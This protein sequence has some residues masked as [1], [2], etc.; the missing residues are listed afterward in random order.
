MK[1]WMCAAALALLPVAYLGTTFAAGDPID[2]ADLGPVLVATLI[3]GLLLVFRKSIGNHLN[4]A[5]QD[6]RETAKVLEVVVPAEGPEVPPTSRLFGLGLVVVAGLVYGIEYALA[7]VVFVFFPLL[8]L[9]CGPLLLLGG[10]IMVHPVFFDAM[11][12]SDRTKYPAVF[13]WISYAVVLAG[14]ALSMF[15]LAGLRG[16]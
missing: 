12:R 6:I 1:P 9:P 13:R 14:F 7:H 4:R 8:L 5:E 3:G 2:W 16:D 15:W 10:L 11:V